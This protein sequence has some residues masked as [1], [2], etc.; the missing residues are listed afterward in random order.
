MQLRKWHSSVETLVANRRELAVA[1]GSFAKSAAILSNGEEHTSLSRALSQ[2]AD[3][4][5]K[6]EAL[7]MEQS[8]TDFGILCELV[9]DYINLIGAIRVSEASHKFGSFINFL[10]G[11]VSRAS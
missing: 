9:K 5:E 1:T 10:L 6:L 11:C 3:L 7:H 4:E 8:S 2:L